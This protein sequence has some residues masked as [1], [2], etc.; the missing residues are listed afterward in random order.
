MCGFICLINK[1][2]KK[3]DTSLISECNNLLRNRGPD[4][5]GYLIYDIEKKYVESIAGEE[6]VKEKKEKLYHIKYFKYFNDDVILSHRRLSIIDI[7]SNAHQPMISENICIVYNGEI[8]NYIDLK[9]ELVSSGYRFFSN[10][11]TEVILNAYKK[12]GEECFEKFDGMFAFILID[13]KNDVLYVVRDHL[14]IK[15]IYMY[16]DKEISIFSSEIKPI[17]RIIRKF[18]INLNK[19][20][21]YFAFSVTD[22]D[23]DTMISD[24]KMI[25]PGTYLMYNFGSKSTKR[26]NYWNAKE[27]INN[28]E[29]GDK[30]DFESVL[31]EH[32]YQSVS[33]QCV[34]DV[35]IGSCLSG[36]IDSSGIVFMMKNVVTDVNTVSF[37]ANSKDWSEEKYIDKVVNM[38]KGVNSYKVSINDIGL[39]EFNKI[40]YFQELPFNS[41]SIIAQY[42]VFELA[43][44]LGIK[45]M[46]DGQGADELFGGYKIYNDISKLNNVKGLYNILIDYDL[47]KIV[48]FNKILPERIII[49]KF[50]NKMKFL[51]KDILTYYK[52]NNMLRINAF[53]F[54]E[55]VL[56]QLYISSLPMLLRYEDRNS[57]ANSVESRVP[58][59][60][61]SL[62]EFVLRNVNNLVRP[63]KQL[64]K[65]VFY[66]NFQSDV[67]LRKDKIN[68][69]LEYELVN[70]KPEFLEFFNY[71]RHNYFNNK[72]YNV[73]NN[74][75]SKEMKF[76]II[77]FNLWHKIFEE[78]T[79]NG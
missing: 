36:G 60:G 14:G 40:I 54:S 75:A 29:N 18:N 58:Y 8:Y 67:F 15:P 13:T 78:F 25:E 10:S 37:I 19:M 63:N 28:G 79:K 77:V 9:N 7:S 45:V 35:K 65:D 69:Y 43:K 52:V 50:K 42:K 51:N 20:M 21:E 41:P 32:L 33:K 73:L 16:E 34:A 11:D 3:I 61:K 66:K 53:D 23:E 17:I 71:N 48:L 46:L 27:F 47:L 62:V 6:T 44:S 74:S 12:Y 72:I 49:Q 70:E 64:L 2:K 76:K 1:S 38:L 39:E 5:E 4:D 59:L 30:Y 31:F 68:F 55:I 57:M 56:N 24:I 22:Y 26:I